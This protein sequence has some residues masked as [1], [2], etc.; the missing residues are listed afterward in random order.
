MVRKEQIRE[1]KTAESDKGEGSA[2]ATAAE[3]VICLARFA[4]I[5]SG[6]G[7]TWHNEGSGKFYQ[8]LNAQN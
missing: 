7:F 4:M 3:A 1:Q 5:D 8:K 2:K 6:D